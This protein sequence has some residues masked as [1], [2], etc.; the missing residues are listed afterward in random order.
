M[1][2]LYRGFHKRT[3]ASREHLCVTKTR[4][5]CWSTRPAFHPSIFSIQP[6]A[7]YF[8][9]C[10][11]RPLYEV[12]SRTQ[13]RYSP[14]N[15]DHR[16]PDSRCNKLGYLSTSRNRTAERIGSDLDSITLSGYYYHLNSPK[17][18]TLYLIY[19]DFASWEFP[20]DALSSSW[21]Q[22]RDPA[23]SLRQFSN[24]TAAL[25]QRIK[26][27]DLVCLLSGWRDSLTTAHVVGDIYEEWVCR[28]RNSESSLY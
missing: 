3:H 23:T 16:V 15:G 18:D 11:L 26:D 21:V 7:W 24:W 2:C 6:T 20:H 17:S 10:Y 22:G 4:A 27:R 14:R 25:S 12:P 5:A 28:I 19:R 13:I 1:A 9:L 8:S